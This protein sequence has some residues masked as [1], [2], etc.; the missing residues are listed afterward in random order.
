MRAFLFALSLAAVAAS[1]QAANPLMALSIDPHQSC[2]ALAVKTAD[3]SVAPMRLKKLSELPPGVLQH[4]VYRV[5]AGC[6]VMEVVL[7][8][9]VYYAPSI[10]T[11]TALAPAG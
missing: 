11:M 7:K 8:G 6:P 9:Q 10:P 5:V 2:K 3:L 4:A 1:A